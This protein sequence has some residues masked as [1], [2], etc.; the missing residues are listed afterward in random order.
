MEKGNDLSDPEI[1]S[2][3]EKAMSE[4]KEIAETFKEFFVNTVP[5]LKISPKE[6]YETD[7]RNDNKLI[8]HYIN[9]SSYHQSY[10]I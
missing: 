9:K 3:V 4:D 2:E 5:S 1:S 6:N 7:V 8:L 10:K